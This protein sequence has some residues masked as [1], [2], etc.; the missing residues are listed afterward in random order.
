MSI[1]LIAIE[2]DLQEGQVAR[3]ARKLG[4]PQRGSPLGK[5]QPKDDT[6]TP[7]VSSPGVSGAQPVLCVKRVSYPQ[8]AVA[9]HAARLFAPV[10][11]FIPYATCQWIEGTGKPHAK[12]GQPTHRHSPYCKHHYERSYIVRRSEVPQQQL[13]AA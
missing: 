13:E 4:L 11:P 8:R 10:I 9:S 12:C 6:N 1:R 5:K 7:V 2:L 3:L